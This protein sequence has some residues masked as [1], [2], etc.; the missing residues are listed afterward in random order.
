MTTR[1]PAPIMPPLRR[2]TVCNPHGERVLAA[3]WD[4]YDAASKAFRHVHPG[5]E[6]HAAIVEA[7][8]RLPELVAA[9][10]ERID[11]ALLGVEES[12][13]ERIR[14]YRVERNPVGVAADRGYLTAILTA[15]ALVSRALIAIEQASGGAS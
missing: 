9:R 11:A 7:D 8:Q 3:C 2:S 6:L 12:L 1:P 13:A 14:E 4:A 15:R 5:G 10:F